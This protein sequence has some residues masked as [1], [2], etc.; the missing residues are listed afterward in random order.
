M[1]ELLTGRPAHAASRAIK[2]LIRST[3]SANGAQVT[4]ALQPLLDS[5]AGWPSAVAATFAAIAGACLQ[6]DDFHRRPRLQ[7]DL[8]PAVQGM[9][10]AA[11]AVA[12]AAA[13]VPAA[14]P[15]VP[16]RPATALLDPDSSLMIA[17]HCSICSEPYKDPVSTPTGQSY[18]RSCITTWLQQCRATCP[19]TRQPLQLIQLAPNYA[20][21]ELAER[22]G[23]LS[24]PQQQQQQQARQQ[25]QPQQQQQQQQ[26]SLAN[27]V[28]APPAVLPDTKWEPPAYLEERWGQPHRLKPLELSG[29]QLYTASRVAQKQTC[30]NTSIYCINGN[31]C[32][33]ASRKGKYGKSWQIWLHTGALYAPWILESCT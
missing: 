25:P 23:M 30:R 1:C 11:T 33:T 21:R 14:Q 13:A 9:A 5:A 20:L 7:E 4:A 2:D 15:A 28:V 16:P 12:A 17:A 27:P 26:A 8:H 6:G 18:C 22:L 24:V 29:V 19:V 10:A 3:S 32:I 31:I